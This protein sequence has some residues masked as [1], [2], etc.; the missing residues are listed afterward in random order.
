MIQD[1]GG[2]ELAD[3][4]RMRT[5]MVYRISGAL[6]GPDELAELDRNGLRTV[7]DLR[8]E[9]EDRSS[10]MEWAE[11]RGAEYCSFPIVVGDFSGGRYDGITRAVQEGRHVEYLRDAYGELA[12]GFGDQ[13]AAAFESLSHRFPCG[14]GCAAGKDRTGIMNAY[15]HV[16]LGASEEA[17]VEAYLSKAPTVEQLRPQLER[18]Y[19]IGPDDEIPPELLHIMAVRPESLTHAFDAVRERGGAEAFLADH[20]LGSAAI[21]RLREALIEVDSPT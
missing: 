14:F 19:S 20:G 9:L 12:V 7:V 10:I 6:A 21:G 18:L 17:A 4:A 13:L 15:L 16:L 2:V 5:G 11:A 3:G 1:A 8:H